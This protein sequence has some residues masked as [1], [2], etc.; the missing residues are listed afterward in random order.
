LNYCFSHLQN[1]ETLT[2]NKLQPTNFNQ[3]N[4]MS[5]TVLVA[6][7]LFDDRNLGT[8]DVGKRPD[9]KPSSSICAI[10]YNKSK[11][12]EVQHSNAKVGKSFPGHYDARAVSPSGKMG[13]FIWETPEER[14][15]LDVFK[16]KVNI[17][18][19]SAYLAGT[20]EA[21]DDA[22]YNLEVAGLIVKT[23]AYVCSLAKVRKAFFDA[24]PAFPEN[25]DLTKF[26][27]SSLVG[28]SPFVHVDPKTGVAFDRYY[29]NKAG[30]RRLKK[31]FV[32]LTIYLSESK[33]RSMIGE[34]V[35]T[36]AQIFRITG[37]KD[38]PT[39]ENPKNRVPVL[40]TSS[41][42]KSLIGGCK[43]FI[44]FGFGSVSVS[45][46]AI[47]CPAMLKMSFTEDTVWGQGQRLVSAEEAASDSQMQWA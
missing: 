30:E 12:W 26:V 43:G 15:P 28:D 8:A 39:M 18:I 37:W 46:S 17:D 20:P 45:N 36:E 38:A 40:E 14:L 23:E 24:N 6:V 3:Q 10:T 35:S 27:N 34:P 29:L 13:M 44:R 11:L 41:I 42:Y 4:N 22:A 16:L 21:P 1:D 47:N 33:R 32:S 2:T 5:Q 25:V 19:S 9:G 31:L 7:P